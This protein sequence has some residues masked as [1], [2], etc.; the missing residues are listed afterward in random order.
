MSEALFSDRHP[1]FEENWRKLVQ[2]LIK[3]L[4]P[5]CLGDPVVAF[6]RSMSVCRALRTELFDEH[7]DFGV[8]MVSDLAS[9]IFDCFDGL[10]SAKAETL[11]DQL[12]SALTHEDLDEG[13]LP[14][15]LG[16][17][18]SHADALA[19]F[20]KIGSAKPDKSDEIELHVWK[21]RTW[22][23]LTSLALALPFGEMFQ[24][25]D[26]FAL[27]PLLNADS[28]LKRFLDEQRY[29]PPFAFLALETIL[30]WKSATGKV[31]TLNRCLRSL[32]AGGRPDVAQ[33]IRF[34]LFTK[35]LGVGF[36]KE[37]LAHFTDAGDPCIREEH[38]FQRVRQHPSRGKAMMF[39]VD[40][41]D[42]A[43]AAVIAKSFPSTPTDIDSWQLERASQALENFDPKVAL[44]LL[45]QAYNEANASLRSLAKH[46]DKPIEPTW[47]ANWSASLI[48]GPDRE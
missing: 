3:E 27:W 43:S 23:I 32:M 14:E 7:L 44:R 29:D 9:I 20:I 40:W 19:L 46:P 6:E 39:F 2:D 8:E 41:P 21:S 1:Y 31:H 37:W 22:P 24:V 15:D 34:R 35:T 36:A 17:N 13:A 26:R 16:L 4:S 47:F 28:M 33:D 18:L 38:I 12:H 25:A 45:R 10:I 42:L 11:V 48:R 30:K 5:I